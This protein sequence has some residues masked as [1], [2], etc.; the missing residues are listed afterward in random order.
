MQQPSSIDKPAID[1]SL[2]EHTVQRSKNSVGF[3]I[4]M[5]RTKKCSRKLPPAEVYGYKDTSS[6]KETGI[7]RHSELVTLQKNITNHKLLKQFSKS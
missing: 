1:H 7:K 2:Q 5:H 6:L 3:A 4:Y